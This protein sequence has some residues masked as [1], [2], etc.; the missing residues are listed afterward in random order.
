LYATEKLPA[1]EAQPVSLLIVREDD[2]VYVELEAFGL[3]LSKPFFGPPCLVRKASAAYL[4]FKVPRQHYAEPTIAIQDVNDVSKLDAFIRQFSLSPAGNSHITFRVPDHTNEISLE[5]TK[6]LDWNR[7]EQYGVDLDALE[8]EFVRNNMPFGL[9]LDWTQRLETAIEL[10]WGIILQPLGTHRRDYFWR[11]HS[12]PRRENQ[13]TEIWLARIENKAGPNTPTAFEL[14]DVGGLQY[15][16]FDSSSQTAVYEDKATYPA[17]IIER[18]PIINFDRLELAATFSRRFPYNRHRFTKLQYDRNGPGTRVTYTNACYVEGR[19]ITV[20][21]YGVSSYGGWLDIDTS[22]DVN[23]GCPISGWNHTTSHGQDQYVKLIREGFIYPWGIHAQLVIESQRWFVRDRRGHFVAPNVQQAFIQFSESNEVAPETESA[24]LRISV[25]T[26][27][28]PPLDP[29]PGGDVNKLALCDYFWPLVGGTPFAFEFEGSDHGRSSKLWSQAAIFVSNKAL[30]GEG[31]IPE[32]GY[33]SVSVSLPNLSLQCVG[34][35]AGCC[36]IPPVTESPRGGGLWAVDSEWLRYPYRFAMYGSQQIALAPSETPGNATQ[37]VVWI[38][39]VRSKQP[40]LADNGEAVAPFL[41]RARMLKI[42]A[43]SV[44][45]F[46]GQTTALLA[47]YRDL[48]GVG[49]EGLDPEPTQNDFFANVLET[50]AKYNTFDAYLHVVPLGDIG[51]LPREVSARSSALNAPTRLDR[52]RALYF[53][54]SAA[55]VPSSLLKDLDPEIRFGIS[56]SSES[57]GAL[58]TPDTP[59]VFL[60]KQRGPVGDNASRPTVAAVRPLVAPYARRTFGIV[61]PGAQSGQS[62]ASFFGMDAEI[63]PGLKFTSILDGTPL[64]FARQNERPTDPAPPRWELKIRGA[65]ELLAL[66]GSGPGQ[67]T[68]ADALTLLARAAPP[69]EGARPFQFVVEASLNW[70]T[71]ALVKGPDNAFVTFIPTRKDSKARLALLARSQIN[72]SNSSAGVEA[73]ARLENFTLGIF[74]ESLNV[75]FES[76]E[77][78]L[79]LNRRGS[80]V[81]KIADVHFANQLAFI[82]NLRTVLSGLLDDFGIKI[83]IDAARI[84]IVQVIA[85]PPAVPGKEPQPLLVGPAIITNLS[86]QWGIICP[87]IGR[88]S[89]SAFFGLSSREHPC[90]VSVPPYGGKFYALIEVTTTGVRLF[91]V[92]IEYGGII[93]VEFSIARGEVSLMAGFFFMQSV[94]GGVSQFEV[95]AFA[96]LTGRLNVARIIDFDGLIRV[97]LRYVGG[98]GEYLEGRTDVSV[99]TRIGLFRVSYG[100]SATRRETRS[101]DSSRFQLAAVSASKQKAGGKRVASSDGGNRESHTRPFA[102]FLRNDWREF[103]EAFA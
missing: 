54:A 80:L 88:D 13:R 64:R 76:L 92:S 45:Q 94:A 86:F 41:P 33:T 2:G 16:N 71:T 96:K 101:E 42:N 74:K 47:T 39:W 9:G 97:T 85:L 8:E 22:I 99:S 78:S 6:L 18:S 25:R 57:L 82:E 27:R 34:D 68:F 59:V 15:K 12:S 24:F 67:I 98:A 17:S 69:D 77:Y 38:E 79:A 84:K 26:K 93:P 50:A 55:S 73:N 31:R 1:V 60:T 3:A 32:P 103:V 53:P 10:P 61:A 90:M 83:E 72:L 35:P 87:I 20:R 43:S 62:L 21:N 46:S 23:P 75:E 37:E 49:A 29:P 65:D 70:A 91:E 95:A 14:V 36:N 11:Y 40:A 102:E 51:P 7:F 28:S 52:I 89:L 5:A 66:F 58:S 100:F 19:T 4:R 56:A 30:N 81:P 48:R 63:L 44:R